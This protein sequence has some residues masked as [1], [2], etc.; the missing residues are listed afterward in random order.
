MGFMDPFAELVSPVSERDHALGPGDA[1]LTLVEYGDYECPQCAR[2]AAAVRRLRK[3]LGGRLRFVFRNFPLTGIH[4]NAFVA[5][6]AAEAAAL[7]GKYW[8]MHDALFARQADLQP[9][10]LLAWAREAGLDSK[11]LGDDVAKGAGN[12][13]I[14]EDLRS[15]YENGVGVTPCFFLNGVFYDGPPDYASLLDA[16]ESVLQPRPA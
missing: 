14:Q 15:G 7:Q 9:G 5:A 1:P 3:T 8:E 13:R 12:A 2:A 4:P 6:Q 11:R 10:V 16:A